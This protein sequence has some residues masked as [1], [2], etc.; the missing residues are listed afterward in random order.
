MHP[1]E[2]LKN[3]RTVLV[4]DW[5][6]K[7]VPEALVLAGFQ[8]Y[9]QGGPGPTDYFVYE[10]NDGRIV[11]RHVGHPPERAELVYSYRP[12]RELPQI[13]AMAKTLGAE[14]I[15]T[16]SGLAAPDT[17]DPKGCWAPNEE[18]ESARQLVE[19][20]G[21]RY[22]SEPYIGAEVRKVAARP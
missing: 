11:A 12:F 5:P 17:K 22:L 16:Q 21:L 8:V 3:V 4:I 10:W 18:L 1:N 13:I 20:A 14:T 9:T 2:F 15:W 7:D 6:S 19:S